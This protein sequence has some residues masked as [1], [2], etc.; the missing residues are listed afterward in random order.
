[1]SFNPELD[2]EKDMYTSRLT[3]QRSTRNCVVWFT[4]AVSRPLSRLVP[5]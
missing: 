1:M 4:Q 2:D 3:G 5:L